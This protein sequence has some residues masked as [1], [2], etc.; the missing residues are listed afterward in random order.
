MEFYPV[1]LRILSLLAIKE[2][3]NLDE[4]EIVKMGFL[5]TKVSLILKLFMRYFISLQRVFF[6][7]APKM[8]KKHYTL[9]EVIPVDLDEEEKYLVL[10]LKDCKFHPIF[11]HYLGGYFCGV[12]QLMLGSEKI[13]FEE[14]KC[15]FKGD[16]YHQY[17]I[18][19]Q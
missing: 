6:R 10:R 9:G 17:L 5:A 8:W 18:K 13:K 1:G 15:P 16:R 12:A 14:T 3:F 19:W 2:I 11:C 7:E 4:K